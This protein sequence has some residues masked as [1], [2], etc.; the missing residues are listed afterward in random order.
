MGSCSI[1]INSENMLICPN[2]PHTQQNKT[3]VVYLLGVGFNSH[4]Q[5]RDSEKNDLRRLC[6]VSRVLIEGGRN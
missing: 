1:K 6:S 4:K 2:L 5:S 3:S